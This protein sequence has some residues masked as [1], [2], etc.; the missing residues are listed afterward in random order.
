MTSFEFDVQLA[1]QIVKIIKT[2]IANLQYT[3]EW[4]KVVWDMSMLW[5]TIN[6][7]KQ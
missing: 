4:I 3:F 6:Q 1:L 2:C 5:R 7:N